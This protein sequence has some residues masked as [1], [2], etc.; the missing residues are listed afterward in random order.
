VQKRGTAY[1]VFDRL[2]FAVVSDNFPTLAEARKE[3]RRLKHLAVYRE[4]C[5]SYAPPVPWSREPLAGG[6]R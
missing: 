6:A 4:V 3:L 1:H 5:A 2:V